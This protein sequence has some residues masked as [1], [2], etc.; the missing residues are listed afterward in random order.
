MA[1]INK[2]GRSKGGGRYVQLHEYIARS[3]AWSRLPPLAKCAWLE[4]GFIYNG[5]NNGKLGVSSRALG[6]A[7]GVTHPAAAKAIRDLIQWGFLE[8]RKS[9]SF[10]QKRL[11]AEYQLTH[12]RCDV[13]GEQ[14][15]KRF[16]KI[17]ETN[18]VP[19][20]S[21]AE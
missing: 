15:T 8:Q 4:I 11:A 1:K 20:R 6:E 12:L 17:G 2:T 19:I 21:A 5:S 13:T 7:L 14:P 16:M 10:S 18:I 9:S 3:Y